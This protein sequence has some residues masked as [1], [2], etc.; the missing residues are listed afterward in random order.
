MGAR[1]EEIAITLEVDT[2][3]RCALKLCCRVEQDLTLKKLY[4]N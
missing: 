2:S 3:I 4:K 1:A